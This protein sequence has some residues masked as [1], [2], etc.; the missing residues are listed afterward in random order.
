VCVLLSLSLLQLL[1]VLRRMSLVAPLLMGAV[2]L[3]VCCFIVGVQ[4]L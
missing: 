3:H 1:S 4:V 2:P